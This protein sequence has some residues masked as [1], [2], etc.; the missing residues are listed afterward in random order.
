MIFPGPLL[1][2]NFK[3]CIL[4]ATTEVGKSLSLWL[5]L[6]P[7][8]TSLAIYD[9]V[10]S[11]ENQQYELS[12]IDSKSQVLSYVDPIRN[13]SYKNLEKALSDSTMVIV[14]SGYSYSDPKQTTKDLFKL[15][16][17][18]IHPLIEVFSSVCPEALLL[19]ATNPVTALVSL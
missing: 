14:T 16:K 12:L 11:L 2:R 5:K 13:H 18:I 9:Q 4:G 7:L 17:N 8:V 3:V 10:P 1:R 6:E 19:I 15:N